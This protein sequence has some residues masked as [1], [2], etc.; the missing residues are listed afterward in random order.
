MRKTDSK[1][2]N[3]LDTAWPVRY[4]TIKSDPANEFPGRHGYIDGAIDPD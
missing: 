3:L 4:W 2:K 1:I